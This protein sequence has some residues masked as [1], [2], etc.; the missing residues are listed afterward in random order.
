MRPIAT[1]MLHSLRSTQGPGPQPSRTKEGGRQGSNPRPSLEPQS[2]DAGFHS[3]ATLLYPGF[4]K[5]YRLR[6]L[7][8]EA[9]LGN[10]HSLEFA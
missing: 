1:L 2:A 9:K 3:A 5:A 8:L 10:Q 7:K 4:G 6:P